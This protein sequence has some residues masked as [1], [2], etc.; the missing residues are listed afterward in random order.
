MAGAGAGATLAGCGARPP[1][2]VSWWGMGAEGE[3]APLLLPP[4][5][6]ATGI[7]IEVQSL[8]WYGV[9]EKLL[10]GHAGGSLPDVMLLSNLWVTELAMLGALAPV[11]PRRRGLIDGQFPAVVDMITIAGTPMA[12]P[13]IVDSWIQ[14]YRRDL[15]STV[16]YPAPP[17]DWAG[18]TRMA[19][20]FKRR[21][22]DR[23]VTL[24]LLDWPEPLMN[25]GAHTGEPLLRDHGAR[26]NFAT[27]GFRAALAFYKGIFDRGFSPRMTGA[28]AGDTIMQFQ[29]GGYAILPSS[30]E[31]IGQF[32][33]LAPGF[34][35][36]RWGAAATPSPSGHAGV[37]AAGNSLGVSATSRQPERAWALVDFLCS[38]PTELHLHAITG[39][40][41][42]R[43]AAWA[44]PA[45][46]GSPIETAV[47]RQIARA[48][49]GPIVPETARIGT[50]VQLVAEHMVRGEYGV[51]AAAREMNRRVDAILAKRRW[52]LDQGLIH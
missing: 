27:P 31:T 13:W 51:D 12:A 19:E 50:E 20:S 5:E 52:L 14:F 2:R 35:A 30:G 23:F 45:L 41:P 18:W 48:V 9:H 10:T 39:D 22:P 42:S 6:R 43:P 26:G 16:G 15:L 40:L 17:E 36:D 44:A 7:A 32:R 21:H 25:F 38:V 3:N 37:W 33:R 49:P 47:G 28:E 1:D 29:R 11:P 34:A 8:P 24:H 4:F 46:A